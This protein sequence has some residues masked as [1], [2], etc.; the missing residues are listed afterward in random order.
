V[1]ALSTRHVKARNRA[2]PWATRRG[3]VAAL[4]DRPLLMIW[5]GVVLFSVGP[6]MVAGSTTSGGVLSFWRLWIGAV[7]L[8]ALTLWRRH[9]SGIRVSR[10]GWGWAV[11]AGLAFGIHQLFFMIAVKATSVVDVALMQLLQ[12][13]LVGILAF[14]AFGERFGVAFRLWSLVA[15]LG[16]VIV[17]L[18][19]TT[20]PEGNPLGMVL[21]VANIVFYALYFVWSKQAMTHM[22]A[23]PFLLGV[24]V[25]AGLAAS[26]FV[27]VTGAPV[28]SIGT[29][30]L[31]IAAG[32]A[33][34]PGSLGHFVTTHAL[35]RV[36]ANVPPVMQ[37]AIPF[38]SGALA[39]LLLGQGFSLMHVVGGVVTLVGVAG[40]LLSPAGR[41]V[42]DRRVAWTG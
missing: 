3:I 16:G 24:A 35:T 2:T 10:R 21:A 5:I 14:L 7:L 4:D 27:A 25:F 28:S 8:G 30:D 20:G 37:L 26:V 13:V 40:A 22:D 33:V 41:Q 38:L 23:L 32:I 19:G 11:A 18:A 1:S 31:L 29:R 9:T 39:W 15:V 36:P 42:P 34:A 12:P 6:V 17:I